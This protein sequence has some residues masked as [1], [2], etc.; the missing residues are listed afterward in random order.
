M[1]ASAD[2]AEVS[3]AIYYELHPVRHCQTALFAILASVDAFVRREQLVLVPVSS[4]K[5]ETVRW[6][7][8]FDGWVALLRFF[9]VVVGVLQGWTLYATHKSN[10]SSER[11]YVGLSHIRRHCTLTG[12]R[13][14]PQCASWSRITEEHPPRLPPYPWNALEPGHRVVAAGGSL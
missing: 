6:W 8:P 10:R 9:L 13:Q 4:A 1:S 14:P 7:L 12:L 3:R 2:R 11:A 5:A